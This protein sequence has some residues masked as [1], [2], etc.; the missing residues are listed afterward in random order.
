MGKIGYI[1]I[2]CWLL[3]CGFPV[4]VVAQNNPYKIDDS[5]YILYRKAS[6]LRLRPQGL[7]IA[8]T[9][10]AEAAKKKDAK[11][12]CLALTIPV[13]YNNNLSN[14]W[15]ALEAA[16]EKLQKFSRETN[17]LQY[18]Y[19]AS[20][21]GINYLLNHGN[22]LRALQ[23]AEA[24][25]EQAIK[26]KY[27][28][29]IFSCIRSIGNIYVSR[30]NYKMSI[31]YYK[32]ALDYMLQYLPEQ[33]PSPLYYNIGR[34]YMKKHSTMLE[35]LEFFEKGIAK[36]KTPENKIAGMLEKAYCLY[37]LERIEDFEDCYDQCFKLI[38]QYGVVRPLAFNKIRVGKA[39]IDRDFDLA[40]SL[41]DSVT[42]T[43]DRL[44]MHT[45]IFVAEGKFEEAYKILAYSQNLK[46]SINQQMQYEDLME[47]NVQVGNERLRQEAQALALKNA[48][49][50]L[51][52]TTLE[53]NHIKSQMELDKMNAEN[54]QLVLSNRNLE[55]ERIRMEAE[56]QR[57]ILKEQQIT[58]QHHIITLSLVVSM[59]LML[60][61][62]LVFYLYKRR[63][64]MKYLRAKNEELEIARD[65]A[66]QADRM[67]MYF[68]QN[69]SHEIRT[70]LNSIVGFS[71][72]ISDSS[73]GFDEEEKKEYSMLIQQNSELLTTIVNDVLDLA[74][75]QSGGYRMVMESCCCNDLCRFAIS[76]VEH[77]KP[78]AVELLFTTEVGD[79]FQIVTDGKRVQ[80]VLI[81]FL[82]NAE[83]YTTEGS[84]LVHCSLSENPGCVTFSVTDTG[85]GIP[86]DHA[87]TIFQRFK[88][89]DDFKQ[90]T[91]LGLNICHTIAE[92]L[93][94][95]VKLDR[96]YT[97]GARFLFILP[98]TS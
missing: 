71:Q 43:V 4:S 35:A 31:K 26:D 96:T 65:L 8:D 49:L 73:L 58:A 48:Q 60:V 64:T 97:K 46:D 12:Q 51:K 74:G 69:M 94:G 3:L 88:K 72:L 30:A 38:K 21:Y 92:R 77:R 40:H 57:N 27:P 79:E 44:G 89:L 87:E 75:L 16:I 15:E 14:N 90:G 85:V 17:Y 63:K 70:P 66:E 93:H 81:N 18:Y 91:G 34:F 22:S 33:D 25:K 36:S 39:V 41:A 62:F 68:I 95:S 47:L 11:A 7:L 19:F 55:L 45:N 50:K 56:H 67:K 2:F 52:N 78:E 80:Q 54:D 53:L 10:Y 13:I 86:A 84:I 42:N 5:L 29:G 6:K 83:K 61:G 32:E 24:M 37:S 76:T 20:S 1:L 28:Y 23:K 9:L 59:L 98:Y 82:T